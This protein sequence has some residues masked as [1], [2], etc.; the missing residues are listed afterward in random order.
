MSKQLFIVPEHEF[1]PVHGLPEKLPA[2]EKILWQGSPDWKTLAN[3]AFHVRKLI[4]YFAIILSLRGV[5]SVAD[6]RAF[7][8]TLLSIVMLA[9]L[10]LI[11]VS[12]MAWMAWLTAR[13]TMYTITNQRIVMRIGIVLSVTFNLPFKALDG[14]RFRQFSNGAGDLPLTIG[15]KDRIAYLHLW[16][17]A[18]PWRFKKPEPMLRSIPE[19]ATVANILTTAIIEA[20]GGSAVTVGNTTG[21]KQLTPLQSNQAWASAV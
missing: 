8:E 12:L 1:E 14:V 20:S 21:I 2:G 19:V 10:A 3:E 16:P 11:S 17:H 4:I 13:T 5:F 15:T 18:R 9:P 7:G 6:G